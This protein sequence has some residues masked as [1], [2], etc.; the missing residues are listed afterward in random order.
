MNMN[1]DQFKGKLKEAV[2]DVTGDENL[3]KAGEADQLA[4]DAKE[5]V[6]NVA[7]KAEDAIDDIKRAVQGE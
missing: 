7:D 4:G 2:G 5:V 1:S 6:Q 3:Q